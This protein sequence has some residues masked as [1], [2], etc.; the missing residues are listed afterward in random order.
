M[1]TWWSVFHFNNDT[2]SWS[3]YSTD[4][5]AADAN[6]LTHMITGETY[7]LQIKS[8]QEVILNR[9]TRNLT[10]VGGNC[11]NQVVW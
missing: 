7:L 2:K 6:T 4:P 1:T 10:C 8:G 3:F 5:D 11:W 9:D